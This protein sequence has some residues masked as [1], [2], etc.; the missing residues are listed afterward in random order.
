MLCSCK[1]KTLQALE[2]CLLKKQSAVPR[3]RR[4]KWCKK[5][6]QANR[7]ACLHRETTERS[8]EEFKRPLRR[9]A[10]SGQTAAVVSLRCVSVEVSQTPCLLQG[11]GVQW[12]HLA[13]TVFVSV[14]TG[15]GQSSVIWDESS[16]V[17]N[18]ALCLCHS[19]LHNKTSSLCTNLQ[20]YHGTSISTYQLKATQ[21]IWYLNAD[22][23]V[24]FIYLF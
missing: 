9:A 3:V 17:L 7:P 23:I 18:R 6:Q 2:K 14:A 20:C 10:E 4:C 8:A 1:K 13:L 12:R 19:F 5:A 15:F 16:P 22:L 11:T 21:L 24:H